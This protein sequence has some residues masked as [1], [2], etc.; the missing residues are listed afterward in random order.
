MS[1]LWIVLGW[2]NTTQ[3]ELGLLWRVIL[4]SFR[5]RTQTIG[6]FEFYYQTSTTISLHHACGLG[7]K[8]Q[9]SNYEDDFECRLH[10]QGASDVG[11]GD[12]RWCTNCTEDNYLVFCH[13]ADNLQ[14]SLIQQHSYLGWILTS[15]A[16]SAKCQR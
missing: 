16:S 3:S 7:G 2:R 10:T 6:Y 14:G 12:L 4:G 8:L 1:M 13:V 11:G 5:L 15:L 9:F